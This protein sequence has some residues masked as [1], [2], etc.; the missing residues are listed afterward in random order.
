MS[1]IDAVEPAGRIVR[2]FAAALEREQREAE[3]GGGPS[4]GGLDSEDAPLGPEHG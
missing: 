4:R 3:Q 1:A 2:R